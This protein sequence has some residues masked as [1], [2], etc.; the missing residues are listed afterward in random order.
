MHERRRTRLKRAKYRLIMHGKSAKAEE[1][2]QQRLASRNPDI[3]HYIG[4]SKSAPIY[5]SQFSAPNGA[6]SAD[7]ACSVIAFTFSTGLGKMRL[8]L[9]T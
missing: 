3:H 2:R 8:T 9:C 6:L 7:V 4:T 1:L 5:L